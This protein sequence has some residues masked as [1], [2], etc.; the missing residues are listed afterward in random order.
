[1]TDQ[2]CPCCEGVGE[3]NGQNKNYEAYYMCK[4][5]GQNWSESVICQTCFGKYNY[6]NYCAEPWAHAKIAERCYLFTEND[7]Y[8]TEFKKR[9][10]HSSRKDEKRFDHLREALKND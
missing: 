9:I 10:L 3:R 7:T 6:E 8:E 2:K 1:M 5:C 4:S